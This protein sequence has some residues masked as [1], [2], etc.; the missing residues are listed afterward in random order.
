MDQ[1]NQNEVYENSRQPTSPPQSMFAP[2]Q[3][4]A[5]QPPY[6]TVQPDS[7]HTLGIISL[8]TSLVGL[9]VVGIVTGLIALR[10]SKRS[11][12]GTN[13]MGLIGLVVGSISVLLITLIFAGMVLN[14]VD[15]NQGLAK[16]KLSITR[17]DSVHTNLETFYNDNNFYPENP[18]LSDFPGI[19]PMALQN[20]NDKKLV[21]VKGTKTETNANAAS[22]P[23]LSEPYLYVPFNCTAGKC[24]GYILT[25]LLERSFNTANPYTRRGLMN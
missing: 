9:G 12:H 19:D 17:L 25:V 18:V 6:S 2:D 11:G 13:I 4:Y 8:I 20:G 24:R 14:N 7:G 21:V 5:A 1:G 15:S 16:D 23:D 10:K 3:Q 22:K